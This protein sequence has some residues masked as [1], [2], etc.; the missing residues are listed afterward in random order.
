MEGLQINSISYNVPA[1]KLLPQVCQICRQD[2]WFYIGQLT[3]GVWDKSQS[4]LSRKELLLPIGEC[5]SCGH[6][7][8]TV[9]YSEELFELL[10]FSDTRPPSIFFVPNKDELSPYGQMVDFFQEELNEE[11][12]VVDFGCGAGNTFKELIRNNVKL[13][14]MTGVDFNPLINEPDINMLEWD[15]NHLENIPKQFWPDGIDLVLS[16]HVLEHV[17]DPVLF[18]TVISEQ[19]S[20]KGKIFIEVPDCSNNVNIEHIAFTNVVHGQHIHY[21]TKDSLQ[22]IAN[23]AG[24]QVTKSQQLTT[25][26][27]PR[28]QLILEK[29][30]QVSYVEC[31]NETA[32]EAVKSQLKQ[33]SAYHQTLV[34]RV[35][36]SIARYGNAALWG[37]GG[38]T[39]QILKHFPELVDFL[40]DNTLRLFDLELAGHTY[41]GSEIHSSVNLNLCSG[42]IYITP[43]FAPTREKMLMIC[44]GWSSCVIDPYE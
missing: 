12:N 34:N 17:V 39:Y 33:V 16:T 43:L 40:E 7:Q 27:I 28:L 4:A 44:K 35:K 1:M 22:M 42:D 9:K 23:K 19:L 37:V 15:L 26:I 11:S 30:N 14:S 13:A 25:R 36:S 3:T 38:D 32:I 18:L 10:Y 29:S 2:S 41:L 5:N 31:C 21:Y 6:V 20:E 8:M 24:L